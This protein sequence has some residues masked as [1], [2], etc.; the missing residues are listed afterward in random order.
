MNVVDYCLAGWSHSL[1]VLHRQTTLALTN[2]GKESRVTFAQFFSFVDD[3]FIVKSLAFCS[4][5]PNIHPRVCSLDRILVTAFS[6]VLVLPYREFP[7]ILSLILLKT[8]A[9]LRN[10]VQCYPCNLVTPSM[11]AVI[12]LLQWNSNT[13]NQSNLWYF[14]AHNIRCIILTMFSNSLNSANTW[15]CSNLSLYGSIVVDTCGLHDFDI[16]WN[17]A[18]CLTYTAPTIFNGWIW[19]AGS[20]N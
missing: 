10:C 13:A 19:K 6:A 11:F 3:N 17:S 1:V 18:Q 2:F 5:F 20:L 8:K 7:G 16:D 12:P 14:S 15:S 4:Q 9:N